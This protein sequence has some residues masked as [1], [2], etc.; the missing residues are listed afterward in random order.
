MNRRKKCD[1]IYVSLFIYIIHTYCIY[2]IYTSKSIINLNSI[3]VGS[4]F[5]TRRINSCVFLY[6]YIYICTL[7]YFSVSGEDRGRKKN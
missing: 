3:N 6:I 5:Y 4:V 2:N 1:S 7:S